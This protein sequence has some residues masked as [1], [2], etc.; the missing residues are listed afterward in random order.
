VCSPGGTT[1]AA[2]EA[3]E[4]HGFRAAAMSAVV[5]ATKRGAELREAA[6]AN[7]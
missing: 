7:K 3:L 1:I 6:A 4:E 5:A 2:V